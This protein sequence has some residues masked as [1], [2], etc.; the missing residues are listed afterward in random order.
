LELAFPRQVGLSQG[1]KERKDYL[2]FWQLPKPLIGEKDLL[3]V[4]GF[5]FPRVIGLIFC[6]YSTLRRPF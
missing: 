4:L 2:R 5:L 6:N 1:V 3:R